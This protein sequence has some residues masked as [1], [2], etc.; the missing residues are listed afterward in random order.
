MHVK[1]NSGA[2]SI[3]LPDFII[4]GAPRCG[5]TWLYGVADRHPNIEM[6][7]PVVPE[8]K[9]FLHDALYERGLAYYA[10]RWFASLS[11]GTLTGE[12]SANYLESKVAAERIHACLPEVR[13]VLVLRNPA[14]RAF[15]NYL[16]SRQ[17]GLETAA[18]EVALAR[19]EDRERELPEEL[20]YARPHALF[21]RGL[22]ADL[23]RP[24]FRRFPRERMLVLRYE[25]II[26]SPGQVAESLHHFVGATP[27]PQDGVDQQSLNSARDAQGTSMNPATR[28]S[29]LDRFAPHNE[30]LYELLGP[31]FRAWDD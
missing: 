9:F 5:T 8:P 19:E 18:F 14:D 11:P 6:A 31:R 28:R 30:R 12:K 13:L 20:R 16:W 2:L 24:Y 29:L 26:A 1:N 17:N 4:A 23:L 25:D 22:Y 15:S 3:R 10:N 27:R 21:S 7:K